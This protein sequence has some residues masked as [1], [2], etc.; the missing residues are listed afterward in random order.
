MRRV[1]PAIVIAVVLLLVW[2]ASSIA[3]ASRDWRAFPNWYWALGRGLAYSVTPL[4]IAGMLELRQR[5]AAAGFGVVVVLVVVQLRLLDHSDTSHAVREAMNYG[6]LAAHLIAMGFLARAMWTRRPWLALAAIAAAVL[7]SPPP[8]LAKLMY[9]AFAPSAWSFYV[10]QAL[11]RLPELIV[12]LLTSRELAR[13]SEPRPLIVADG[14]RHASRAFCGFSGMAALVGI[15]VIGQ[16]YVLTAL[17]AVSLAWCAYGLLRAART[18]MHRWFV[19]A[20]ATAVLWCMS[21]QLASLS[22]G[23]GPID[24]FTIALMLV[25]AAVYLK[26]ATQGVVDKTQIQA[27]GIGAIMMFVTAL[28]MT[29]FLVPESQSER[30]MAALEVLIGFVIALGAWMLSGLCKLAAQ[31]LESSDSL[32]PA[33]RVL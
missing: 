12:I 25:V 11:R 27:K 20:A 23:Y 14:F 33:A 4:M 13:E 7:M 16:R 8:P 10:V 9:D 18:P 2:M 22:G 24:F 5:G 32:L 6:F 26:R 30:A 3:L 31:R 19:T 29:T 15:H 21:M 17:S 1:P 28:A